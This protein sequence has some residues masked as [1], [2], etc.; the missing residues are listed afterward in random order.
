MP[1]ITMPKQRRR[2]QQGVAADEAGAVAEVTSNGAS[3]AAPLEERLAAGLARLALALRSAAWE[4]AG[5]AGLSPTQ[6]QILAL[7]ARRESPL[8]WRLAEVARE[9]AISPPTASEAVAALVAKGLVGKQRSA[10]D[11][12]AL[13]LQLTTAGRRRARQAAGWPSALAAGLEV[14][15]PEERV[16]LLGILLKMLR[17]LELDG[18]LAPARMCPTC[19]HFRPAA[20]PWSAA[21]DSAA[22][23]PE[24]SPLPVCALLGAAL[25]A[26]DLRLDCADHLPLAEPDRARQ[27]QA[28]LASADVAR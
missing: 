24:P 19:R 10:A 20:P 15:V 26:R 18:Q 23:V 3:G 21:A 13:E 8:G 12:R 7:L 4:G 17:G 11:G 1:K 16:A 9:L 2:G 5:G 28:F 6:G 27:W 25:A 22:A 14:L